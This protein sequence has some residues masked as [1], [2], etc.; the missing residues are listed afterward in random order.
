MRATTFLSIVAVAF[1]ASSAAAPLPLA[2]ISE[3]SIERRSPVAVAQN[4]FDKL[5]GTFGSAAMDKCKGP[6]TVMP[7]D[8]H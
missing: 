2:K 3:I 7:S 1:S 5:A 6:P 4:L 8:R